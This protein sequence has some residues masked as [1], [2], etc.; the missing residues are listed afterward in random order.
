MRQAG[1]ESI[2]QSMNQSTRF[3]RM[4][5]LIYIELRLMQTQRQPHIKAQVQS[6]NQKKF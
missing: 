6:E 3:V 4:F 2:N 1:R 5:L